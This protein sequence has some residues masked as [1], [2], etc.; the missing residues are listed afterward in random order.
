MTLV[1]ARSNGREI[2]LISD[3]Q[4]VDYYSRTL[5]P[6]E[7]GLKCVVT[8]PSCC[9]SYAGNSAVAESIL[10]PVVGN[11]HWDRETI[12]RHVLDADPSVLSELDLI[13]AC[14]GERCT[15][16]KISGGNVDEGL[17]VAWVGDRDAF[18]AYQEGY[19]KERPSLQ[20][21][22]EAMH[23]FVRME[24]AFSDVLRSAN[25]VVV[26]GF[27]IRVT[28]RPIGGD[29]F[30]YL[31]G[32]YGSGFETVAVTSEPTSVLKS[33]GVKG[34]SYNYTLLVPKAAG[35]GAVAVYVAEARMGALW[36][37][38][39][40]WKPISFREIGCEAFIRAIEDRHDLAMTGILI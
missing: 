37:P 7:G 20:I 9:V 28:S 17:S 8:S 14:T 10:S 19:H 36:C 18:S 25:A 21:Y 16:D 15:I 1:V 38:R 26:G 34:G 3:T 4:L 35:V 22:D 12:L 30:R 6:L 5:S 23:D 27:V 11:P 39:I 33:A 29:G 2:R 40:A 32:T 31:A 13:V 24:D